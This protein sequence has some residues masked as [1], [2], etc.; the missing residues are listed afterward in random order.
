[1]QSS[2][3]NSQTHVMRD[4]GVPARVPGSPLGAWELH[5]GY[6]R[7]MQRVT[8]LPLTSLAALIWHIR[9]SGEAGTMV[10]PC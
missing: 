6:C 8:R 1:M 2:V 4:A 7:R 10:L 3:S 9:R 5:W